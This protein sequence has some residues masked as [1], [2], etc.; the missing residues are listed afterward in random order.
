MEEEKKKGQQTDGIADTRH[1]ALRVAA[2]PNDPAN[3]EGSSSSQAA[4]SSGMSFEDRQLSNSV[5]RSVMRIT[6]G[7]K[8]W[9]PTQAVSARLI[10]FFPF[11]GSLFF[12]PET[13][14]C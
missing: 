2:N 1:F 14:G 10:V 7:V 11:V 6:H 9:D 12:A 3:Q 8:D 5:A 4:T 13:M